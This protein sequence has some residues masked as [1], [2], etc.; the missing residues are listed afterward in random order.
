METLEWVLD[1]GHGWLSVPL[2][3]A[4]KVQGISTFSYAG[5]GRAYLE[6]DCDA[7]LFFDH[8]E[9]DPSSVTKVKHY[10]GDAPCRRF[11][12]FAA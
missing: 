4:R 2:S 8:Y 3:L 10:S 11:A 9:I 6:E 12:R 5:G 1:A 7:A